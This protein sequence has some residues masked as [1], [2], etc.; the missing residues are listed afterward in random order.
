MCAC[1]RLKHHFDLTVIVCVQ[2]SGVGCC[3]LYEKYSNN[4]Y[5][6]QQIILHGED[7]NAVYFNGNG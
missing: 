5:T 4:K 2:L 1:V 6:I 7:S 3:N